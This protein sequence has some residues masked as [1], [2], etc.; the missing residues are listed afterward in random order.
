MNMI[1]AVRNT[2]TN[3]RLNGRRTESRVTAIICFLAFLL[4][5]G[6]AVLHPLFVLGCFAVVAALGLCLLAIVLAR[7]AGLELWQGLL[8]AA[9]TGYMVLNYGFE[10]L[11]I[12]LGGFPLIISYGLMYASMAFAVFSCRHTILRALKEPAMVCVLAFLFLTFL[13]LIVDVPHYGLWAVRDASMFLD[14]IFLLLGLLW[15]MKHSSVMLLLKWLMVVFLLN[16]GYSFLMPWEDA[17]SSWSPKSGVFVMTPIVGNYRGNQVFLLLGA[18]FFIL[19]AQYVVRWPRWIVLLLAAAQLFG[20]AILQARAEYVGILVSLIVFLFLGETGKF[21]KLLSL[22]A[23]PLI[24]ILIL[25]TVGI[26]ISGRIGP[27]NLA[28]FKEHIRSIGGAEG[29]PGSSVEGRAGWI[30]QAMQHFWPNPVFGEGFGL[31]LIEFRDARSGNMVRQPHNSS[32][33]VLARLGAVG[34]AVWVIFNLRVLS[35]FIRGFRQRCRWNPVL[36][37]LLLWLFL[38]YLIDMINIS[39][40]AGLEFPSS[41][42][43]FLFFVGLALGLVSSQVQQ[44]NRLEL[45]TP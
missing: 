37:N 29:T 3:Y 40:E 8:L 19:L 32:V 34:F 14:G 22:L 35:Q 31:P 42:I 17:L 1:E 21:A 6:F 23:P 18:L 28:F 9:L 15:S 7:R 44:R 39:T 24:V 38:A 43:P 45:R 36:S 27:V 26:E 16:L 12:H 4:L 11:A 33:S 5:G 41:D 10:N 25:T 13:H 2:G 20:L 30:D